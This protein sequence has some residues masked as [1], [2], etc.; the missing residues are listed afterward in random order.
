MWRPPKSLPNF[1]LG[2]FLTFLSEQEVVL[3]VLIS[4][5]HGEGSKLSVYILMDSYKST[6]NHR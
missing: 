3:S 5:L 4:S 1:S 6:I 2:F